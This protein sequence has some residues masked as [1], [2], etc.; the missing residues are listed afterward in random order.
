MD[1]N[2]FP[3]L[4]RT[5]DVFT[6][7]YHY[8]KAKKRFLKFAAFGDD[9]MSGKTSFTR[10]ELIFSLTCPVLTFL[11]GAVRFINELS[12][13]GRF[14]GNYLSYF[15]AMIIGCLLPL[16]LTLLLGIH[17]ENYLKK[18]LIVIAVTYVA[19]S[20]IGKIGVRLIMFICFMLF[21]IGAI[22]YQVLKVQDE[23]L[24]GI[25][26]VVMIISDPIV[27]WTFRLF[28]I[29]VFKIRILFQ[30]PALTGNFSV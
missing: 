17:T 19:F 25:G 10:K 18:R 24:S 16:A 30:L 8:E 3:A 4:Y 15:A 1:R 27:Y 23:K 29:E 14:W 6:K 11:W 22:I 26:R 20:F 28:M 5:K 9:T 21:G 7:S 12:W 2:I 13:G